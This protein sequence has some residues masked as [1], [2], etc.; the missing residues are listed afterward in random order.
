MF[1]EVGGSRTG[2]IQPREDNWE[3]TWMKK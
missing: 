3:A 2:S 1:W